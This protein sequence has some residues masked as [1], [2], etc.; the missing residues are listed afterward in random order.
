M[1]SRDEL[2]LRSSECYVGVYFPR[3]FAT[4]EINTKIALSW[5]LKQFVIPVHT[6]FS[7]HSFMSLVYLYPSSCFTA[8]LANTHI[9]SS[10][11]L[12]PTTKHNSV[13]T[14]LTLDM[15]NY[16]KDYEWCVHISYHI[17]D[18]VPQTDTKFT[19]EKPYKCPTLCWQYHACGR[20]DEFRARAPGAMVSTPQSR[21]TSSP[22]SV[23]VVVSFISNRTQQ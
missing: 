14:V 21:N 19:T 8:T 10:H 15:L 16:F 18:F 9:I 1:H 4:R 6:L 23:V 13:W 3:C 11:R 17:L 20:S 7:I 2:L 22:A 5:A 12:L